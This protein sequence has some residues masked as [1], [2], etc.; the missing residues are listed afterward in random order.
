MEVEQRDSYFRFMLQSRLFAKKTT[1]IEGTATLCSHQPVF[2][3]VK[4][5]SAAGDLLLLDIFY[6]S[7]LFILCTSI[8]GVETVV[9][10]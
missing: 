10:Q 9:L 5:N 8:R 6:A 1:G 7:T 3:I 2:H 4:C